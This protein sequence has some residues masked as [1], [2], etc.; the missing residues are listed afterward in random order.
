MKHQALY[1]I[2]RPKTFAQVIG[3]EHITLALSNQIKS[4]NLSH[5]YIFNGTRGV[6]K[7]SVARIFARAV[8]C[9]DNKN[10]EPCMKCKACLDYERGGNV[11]IIEI[12]AAS[13]NGVQDARELADRVTYA[14]NYSRY[15]VYIID[16]AHMI[17]NN[18]FNALLK[19]IEE[20]PEHAIFVLCTTEVQAFPATILSRCMRFDFHMVSVENLTALLEN[21]FADL[22]ISAQKEALSAIAMA[23]EGS[24]RDTLTV[25]DR[26]VALSKEKIDYQSVLDVLGATNRQTL[27]SLAD[28]VLSGDAKTL[29]ET[30]VSLINEGKSV[31]LLARDLCKHMR[32]LAVIST[33]GDAR[34]ILRLPEELYFSLEKSAKS[35]DIKKLLRCIDAFSSLEYRLR[36]SLSPQLLFEAVA[37]K[38][39]VKEEEGIEILEKRIARLEKIISGKMGGDGGNGSYNGGAVQTQKK[40]YE[41]SKNNESAKQEAAAKDSENDNS[42][43]EDAY[44]KAEE[45]NSGYFGGDLGGVQN[46]KDKSAQTGA[47]KEKLLTAQNSEMQKNDIN[48]A[49]SGFIGEKQLSAQNNKLINPQEGTYPQENLQAGQNIASGAEVNTQNAQQSVLQGETQTNPHKKVAFGEQNQAQGVTYA[50]SKAHQAQKGENAAAYKEKGEPQEGKAPQTKNQTPQSQINRQKTNEAQASQDKKQKEGKKQEAGFTLSASNIWAEILSVVKEQASPLVKAMCQG[51]NKVEISNNAFKVFCNPAQFKVLSDRDY[52]ET[53]ISVLSKYK[54]L[55]TP[56][57]EE[58]S[59]SPAGLDAIIKSAGANVEIK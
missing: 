6:G 43:Q 55:F 47:V 27:I 19:T 29:L 20:P 52:G 24:V 46:Y 17:T 35:A 3:Q 8:N 49:E 50:N 41:I 59:A 36:S 40:T 14:P 15:K 7:T 16:E 1:R 21:I 13:N 57:R 44:I 10:G 48:F 5:A 9:L 42:L 56:I 58:V 12:D 2:Y 31:Y 23:G 33:C 37:L 18:A 45:K 54:L 4:G 30:T 25:A 51:I 38:L 11:D 28:S 22:K 53:F 26:C 34:D 32:D 39:A